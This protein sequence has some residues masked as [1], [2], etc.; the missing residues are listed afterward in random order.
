MTKLSQFIRE[1][2]LPIFLIISLAIIYKN[3]ICSFSNSS[4][5]AD[6]ICEFKWKDGF[7]LLCS[8][9]LVKLVSLLLGFN[10]LTKRIMFTLSLYCIAYSI[11][12]FPFLLAS[13]FIIIFI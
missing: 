8:Y 3:I 9:V 2:I 13:F 12:A 1:A 5:D 11:I 4:S 10:T 6:F 7:I